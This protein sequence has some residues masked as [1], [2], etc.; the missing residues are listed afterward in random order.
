[1]TCRRVKSERGGAFESCAAAATRL[2][3][4]GRQS[5]T[6]TNTKPSLEKGPFNETL[7]GLRSLPWGW[8]ARKEALQ[9]GREQVC[10][11]KG[12][13]ANTPGAAGRRPL[14]Q[15]SA[16]GTGSRGR[17]GPG[18]APR[19]APGWVGPVGRSLRTLVWAVGRPEQSRAA[20][21]AQMLFARA[22]GGAARLNVGR[23]L[24]F[25]QSGLGKVLRPRPA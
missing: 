16:E 13:L 14:L 4:L 6:S 12:Q 23:M 9:A 8:K 1:M 19:R 11:V 2:E 20:G 24:A 17:E 22:E 3:R 18:C 5:V 7:Q 15:R 10:S 21:E 25:V